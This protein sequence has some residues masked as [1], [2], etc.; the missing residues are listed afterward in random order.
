[1]T[2]ALS[3]TGPSDALAA[4]GWAY[5]RGL[6]TVDGVAA[7]EWGVEESRDAAAVMD[8]IHRYVWAYDDRNLPAVTE[9]FAEE[10]T[11]TVVVGPDDAGLTHSG[12]PAVLAWMSEALEAQLEQRRHAVVNERVLRPGPENAQVLFTMLLFTTGGATQSLAAAGFYRVDL[13]RRDGGWL[14]THI[15]SGFDAPAGVLS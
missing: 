1:M 2:E 12:R 5:R 7:G 14:I 6:T 13:V 10:V 11:W 15:D 9:I 3:N 4:P 8:A